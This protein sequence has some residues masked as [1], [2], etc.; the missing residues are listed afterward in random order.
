MAEMLLQELAVPLR[1]L[2]V[3]V[4][5]VIEQ[6]LHSPQLVKNSQE[7]AKV[8]GMAPRSLYRHLTPVGLQPRQLIVGARLLRAYTL[9]REPG[10]RLKEIAQKLGYADPDTLSHLLQ[11]WT[12]HNAKAIRRDVPPNEFVRLLAAHM[13]RA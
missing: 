4:T 8:A 7:L 12:G 9:L 10:S 3:G 6:L 2:P 11:E 1:A 13:L 5:R